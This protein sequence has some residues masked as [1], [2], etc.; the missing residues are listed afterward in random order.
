[1]YLP[2]MNHCT[3]KIN[4][5]N[6]LKKNNLRTNVS[7]CSLNT[8]KDTVWWLGVPTNKC[9]IWV[10]CGLDVFSKDVLKN[11]SF[12]WCGEVTCSPLIFFI[13][14]HQHYLS[15]LNASYFANTDCGSGLTDSRWIIFFLL[16]RK[17]TRM[18]HFTLSVYRSEMTH[19]NI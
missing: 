1:M 15:R 12:F 18:I 14:S 2:C 19:Q 13:S 7:I 4:N 11:G 16:T 5:N 6:N 3:E 9:Y 17:R 10:C 8:C